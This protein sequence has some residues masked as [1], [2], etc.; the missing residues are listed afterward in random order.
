M[1]E[2]LVAWGCHRHPLL[3]DPDCQRCAVIRAYQPEEANMANE[4]GGAGAE[5]GPYDDEGHTYDPTSR[6]GGH[7][8]AIGGSWPHPLLDYADNRVANPRQYDVTV[9]VEPLTMLLVGRDG[10][11]MIFDGKIAS[12]MPDVSDPVERAALIALLRVTADELDR[13]S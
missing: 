7:A 1:A 4:Q 6:G 10:R 2:P 8:T 12:P 11:V 3:P 13:Q 9:K 5:P